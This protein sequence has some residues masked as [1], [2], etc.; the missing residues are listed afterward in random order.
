MSGSGGQLWF[1]ID[2]KK[3]SREICRNFK[4]SLVQTGDMMCFRR[5]KYLEA[6]ACHS[7]RTQFIKTT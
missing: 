7:P 4:L 2:F 1:Q 3:I 6:E 5:M